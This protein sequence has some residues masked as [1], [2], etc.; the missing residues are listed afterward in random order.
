MII[1]VPALFKFS[2]E[3][4]EA[5]MQIAPKLPGMYEDGKKQKEWQALLL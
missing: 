1:I 4:S 3:Q 2:S 5:V